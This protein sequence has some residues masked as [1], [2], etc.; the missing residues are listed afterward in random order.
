MANILLCTEGCNRFTVCG[1]RGWVGNLEWITHQKP[2]IKRRVEVQFHFNIFDADIQNW[3]FAVPI[4]YGPILEKEIHQYKKVRT[5]IFWYLLNC[6][7]FHAMWNKKY[8]ELHSE[9]IKKQGDMLFRMQ[10][11]YFLNVTS[12]IL[13]LH[14]LFRWV[15]CRNSSGWNI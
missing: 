14:A 6:H 3:Y 13:V 11:R 2:Y 4:L 5:Y 15:C 9:Q 12:S 8:R 10:K 7:D 1:F